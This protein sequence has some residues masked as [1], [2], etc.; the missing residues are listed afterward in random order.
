MFLR[1][2]QTLYNR[3]STFEK[4]EHSKKNI[5]SLS[6]SSL[7]DLSLLSSFSLLS[8]FPF[9]LS[10]SLSFLSSGQQL[11]RRAPANQARHPGA[12]RTRRVAQHATHPGVARTR[13]GPGATQAGRQAPA[14]ARSAQPRPDPAQS[15]PANPETFRGQLVRELSCSR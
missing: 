2:T 15:R 12:A 6:S 7:L 4:P 5:L 14:Q 8:F 13:R 1:K 3:V 10:S 9:F 11:L